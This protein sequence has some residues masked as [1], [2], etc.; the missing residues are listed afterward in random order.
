M[1]EQSASVRPALE[2]AVRQS[3]ACGEMVEAPVISLQELAILRG[4]GLQVWA[5]RSGVAGGQIGSSS[6]KSSGI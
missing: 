6:V 2:K 5:P 1:T 3:I 4:L